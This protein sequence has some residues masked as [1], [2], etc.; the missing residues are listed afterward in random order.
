MI[1]YVTL[2]VKDMAR[3]EEFYTA[4]LA[5]IGGKKLMDGGRIK[6]FGTG[7]GQ[8]MI[9]ICTPYNEDAQDCGNGNMVAIPAGDEDAVVALYN[10]ALELGATDEGEPGQ[11]IPIFY[12]G[13]V[14]DP[15]GN[16]LCFYQMKMG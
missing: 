15:E 16:K 1:G 7:P 12:G 5:E 13:Y 6:F 14:R 8:S 10:K 2:G 11:R 3:A 4:L 9:A